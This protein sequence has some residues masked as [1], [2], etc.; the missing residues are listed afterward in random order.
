MAKTKVNL[1]HDTQVNEVSYVDKGAIG[2]KFYFMKRDTSA[3]P[4]TQIPEKQ[5]T[6]KL[7]S[8]EHTSEL[9]SR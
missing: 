5:T 3:E 6:K 2:Q 8:E 4:E 1:L 9:Q 7:R